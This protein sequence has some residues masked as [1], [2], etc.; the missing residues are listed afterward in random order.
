MCY[1]RRKNWDKNGFCLKSSHMTWHSTLALKQKIIWFDRTFERKF[2][3]KH[4][5]VKNR[6]L[7]TGAYK[8]WPGWRSIIHGVL[9]ILCGVKE[10]SF[11]L[12]N[13]ENGGERAVCVFEIIF[14]RLVEFSSSTAINFPYISW[15]RHILSCSGQFTLIFDLVQ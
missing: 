15:R 6:P 7:L 11:Q 3:L 9:L 10:D 14:H 5:I 13:G 1:E 2:K 4:F 8:N 12:P